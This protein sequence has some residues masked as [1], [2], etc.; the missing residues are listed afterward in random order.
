VGFES[1][2]DCIVRPDVA[3]RELTRFRLLAAESIGFLTRGLETITQRSRRSLHRVQHRPAA[4]AGV[5]PFHLGDSHP[6]GP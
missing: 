1:R 2:P 5:V 3:A 6:Q 4:A